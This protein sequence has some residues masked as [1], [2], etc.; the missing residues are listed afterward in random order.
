MQEYHL[1]NVENETG[2]TTYH[3][4][5][6]TIIIGRDTLSGIRISD[7]A[8]MP[9]HVVLRKIRVTGGREAFIMIGSAG[10][11]ASFHNGVWEESKQFRQTLVTGDRFQIGHTRLSYLSAYMTESEYHTYFNARPILSLDLNERE[12]A[13]H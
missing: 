2:S 13:P 7:K 10:K 9:H 4:N 6:S 1:L 11:V 5:T 12:L 8:V 3:L